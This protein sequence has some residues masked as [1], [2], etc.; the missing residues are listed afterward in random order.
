MGDKK[1]RDKKKKIIRLCDLRPLKD[2]KAGSK[3]INNP[4]PEPDR[5]PP[6]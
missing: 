6:G 3:Q 5:R 2:A 4:P 1:V